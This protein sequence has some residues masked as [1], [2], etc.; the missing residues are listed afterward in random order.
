MMIGYFTMQSNIN[1]KY[2]ILFKLLLRLLC[3]D[4]LSSQVA[5][6]ERERK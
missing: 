6:I 3:Y 5:S 2:Y 1:D 4:H